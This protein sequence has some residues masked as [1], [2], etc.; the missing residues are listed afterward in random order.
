MRLFVFDGSGSFGCEV[1]EHT[2]NALDLACY[3]LRNLVEQRVGDLLDRGAG[4][5]NGIDG[6]DDN[7]PVKGALAVRDSGGLEVRHDGEIL[8]DLA[9]KSGGSE[10]LAEDRVGL[11]DCLKSVA[12]DC[13]DAAD[14][15][16]GTGE[17]L[18]I[19]HAVGQAERLADAA[20]L[21]LIEELYRLDELESDVIGK[22]AD[23]VV[24]LET[25]G[26]EYVGVDSTLSEEADTVELCAL[27]IEHADELSADDLALLLGV[28]NAGELIE[29]AVSGVDIFE[30]CAELLAE[31]VDDLL[32]LTLA[33]ETVIDVDA[34]ELF[35]DRLDEERGDYGGVDS[36]GES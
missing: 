6:A 10:L 21:V 34:G 36:A 1:V 20:Y 31:N 24:S 12:R 14:A 29:E 17:R 5:V 18:T 25:L 15:E 26:L 9:L 35:A 27:L 30:V 32:A 11:A 3:T 28:R 13:A 22:T 8:P 16:A 19:N 33:H 7:R 2:V 4:G 23:V